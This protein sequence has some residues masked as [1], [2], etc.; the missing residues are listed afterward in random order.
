MCY[1]L[2]CVPPKNVYVD[3]LSPSML[4]Y[5]HIGNRASKE[6]ILKLNEG[7]WEK[8]SSNMT[9]ILIE[10]W[11]H[12]GYAHTEERACENTPRKQPSVSQ[13]ERPPNKSPLLA[14]RL[15]LSA[16][17]TARKLIYVVSAI[18]SV[19]FCYDSSRKFIYHPWISSFLY[20]TYSLANLIQFQCFKISSTY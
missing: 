3:T 19:A 12:Q 6:V 15:G 11:R 8:P 10:W 13:G 17:N 20:Y 5:D 16:I 7:I 4:E 14:P 1:R 18:Q 9:G 2:N